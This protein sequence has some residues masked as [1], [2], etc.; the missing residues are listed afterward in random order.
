MEFTVILLPQTPLSWCYSYIP[1]HSTL[2]SGDHHVVLFCL[3]QPLPLLIDKRFAVF[4]DL[5][6]KHSAFQGMY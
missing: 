4:K 2:I 3:L 5:S 6:C 1:P